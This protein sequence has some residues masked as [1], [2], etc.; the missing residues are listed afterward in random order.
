MFKDG[1]IFGKI[2]IIDFTVVVVVVLLIACA[3]LKFSKFDKKSDDNTLSQTIEYKMMVKSIR[4]YTLDAFEVGDI[5]YDSQSKVEIG[6][7]KNIESIA[8]TSYENLITGEVAEL[9]N[10]YRY[11][12]NFT[13]ETD[14][15]VTSE[16]Y[17]ANKSIELKVNS[18]KAIETKYA[19]TTGTITDIVLK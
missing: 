18:T 19:K 12:V 14:G 2:N 6:K 15:V 7:I 3:C 16:A 17:Y 5:V 13:I 11:D 8:S 4:N 9:E 1:K 10:P